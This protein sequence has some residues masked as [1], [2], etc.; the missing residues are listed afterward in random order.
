MCP[1]GEL[2][3]EFMRLGG[4]SHPDKTNTVVHI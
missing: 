2:T 1:A 4:T 3:A